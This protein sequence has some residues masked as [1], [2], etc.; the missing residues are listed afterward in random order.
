[1]ADAPKAW[2]NW[3]PMCETN[4]VR[5]SAF[6]KQL[7]TT[8]S[9]P[10]RTLITSN[11]SSILSL[12]NSGLFLTQTRTRDGAA[13][14]MPEPRSD[15]RLLALQ[16]ASCW[17]KTSLCRLLRCRLS[18]MRRVESS[19]SSCWALSPAFPRG[20]LVISESSRAE[21][22]TWGR[23]L[24]APNTSLPCFGVPTPARVSS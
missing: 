6:V 16:S 19:S 12:S 5:K 15:C 24:L 1:V 22:T 11:S 8:I 18:N 10:S 2:E 21:R 20:R 3:K 7:W 17:S 4:K 23:S 14:V 9:E 13:S